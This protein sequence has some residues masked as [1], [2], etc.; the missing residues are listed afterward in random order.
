MRLD[1]QITDKVDALGDRRDEAQAALDRLRSQ[2]NL[3]LFVV[4]VRSFDGTPAREWAEQTV[5]RS[6][7]GDR[8]ALLAVAT[9]DR[10]YWYS[11]DPESPLSDAQLDEVAATAIEPAL[12]KNDWAGA[13]IAAADGYRAALAGKPEQQPQVGGSESRSGVSAYAIVCLLIV[14]AAAAVGLFVWWRARK[15]ATRP[16]PAALGDPNDPFPGVSTQ[17]LTDR[18]NSQLLEL[19][20]ALRTSEHELSMATAQYGAEATTQFTSAVETARQEVGEAFRLRMLLEEAPAEGT[21]PSDEAGRRRLL[22][23]IVRLSETAD[24]RLDAEAEAFD[25]LREL[26]THLEQSIATLGERRAATE[27]RLPGALAELDGLRSRFVG[28]TLTAVSSNPEQATERLTFAASAL[29]KASDEVAAGQRS[30]AALAVRAAEQ[31]VDQADTLLAAIAK[32]GADLAAAR[33]AVQTLLVE[34]ESD[35][36]AGRAAQGSGAAPPEVTASLAS[37]VAGGEQAVATARAAQA[38]PTM[39]PLTVVRQ[40]QDADAGLDRALAD[41]RDAAQR[42]ARARA[43]LDQ[44]ILAARTEISAATDFVNTRRGAVRE[45]ARTLLAEAQRH[46][47]QAIALTADDPVTALAEAQQADHMAEQAS[48]AAQSDVDQWAPPSG[49]FAGP[50]DA[51]PGGL[52]GAIL[53]GILM[54][55]GRRGHTP[56]GFGG[57]F[58]GGASGGWGGHS[59]GGFGGSQS[60]GRRGGGGRF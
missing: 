19:D 36:A 46:L 29:R 27:T 30:A 13:V 18:A 38:G 53:G 47:N 41:M 52:A 58:G 31:A 4:F 35:L 48:R 50:G 5:V 16:A 3:Q 45:Q 7:L 56:G 15:R 57:G 6:D 40:L 23:D 32:V 34:V 24:A 60:S 39:D 10:A 43:M 51:A 12:A 28:Q 26:E 54:G 42:T 59:P 44:A 9:G 37:A 17:E 21:A 49:G 2:A 8:D 14:L 11:F 1:E 55:G 22:A 33:E 25:E 20:D